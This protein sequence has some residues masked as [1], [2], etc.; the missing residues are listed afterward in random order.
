VTD[1]LIT[2]SGKIYVSTLSLSIPCILES[3]H[4]VGHEGI[5]KILHWL[6]ADFH[7]IDVRM[8]VLDFIK[9][10]DLL[11]QQDIASSSDWLAAPIG[12]AIRRLDR[13]LHGFC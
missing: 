11:V 6:R 7:V 8:T 13:H 2:V 9:V 12:P 5:E 1:G 4:G 3:A 10:R